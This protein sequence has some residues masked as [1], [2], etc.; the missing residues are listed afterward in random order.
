MLNLEV[1]EDSDIPLQNA[2]NFRR[3]IL[4]EKTIRS[5]EATAYFR[6][7]MIYKSYTNS[8]T[9]CIIRIRYH[10][11]VTRKN[12]GRIYNLSPDNVKTTHTKTLANISSSLR[13]SY[14]Q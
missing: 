8:D 5:L 7:Y 9:V 1:Y 11:A 10:I 4:K 3:N 6:Y 14:N 2:I 13:I 12:W